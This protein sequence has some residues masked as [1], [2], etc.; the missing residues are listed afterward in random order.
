MKNVKNYL[1]ANCFLNQI[2]EVM[3][4]INNKFQKSI[5][6][7]DSWPKA[8]C[9]SPKPSVRAQSNHPA[10]DIPRVILDNSK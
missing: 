9:K 2:L 8:Q 10:Q 7:N 1:N 5:H 3:I 4:T 6:I